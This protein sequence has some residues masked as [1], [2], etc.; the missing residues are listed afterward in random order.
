MKK[1][2]VILTLAVCPALAE[3][4]AVGTGSYATE[5]PADC[6]ALP[7]RIY[8]TDSYKG[9]PLTNQWWSSLLFEE[10]S[11]NLFAH[12]LGMVATPRGL[13]VTYVGSSI[14]SSKDAIMGAGVSK[15]GDFVISH[16]A[17]GK[18]PSAEADGHSDWFV[19]AAF[20]DGE[21]SLKTSFGH[22]SPFV[23]CLYGGGGP[24]LVFPEKPRLWSGSENDPVLGITVQGRHYGL[25]GAGGSTWEG[26]GG[27][28][29]TNRTTKP[30]FSIAVL[31]DAEPETLAL[32]RRHAYNHVTDT[33]LTHE[34]GSGSVKA[35]YSF[36]VKRWEGGEKGTITALYPHQW[37]YSRADLTGISYPSVRG[38]M[39]V[40]ICEG[41]STETPIHG[42]LPMLPPQ[43]I[44]N[45]ERILAYLREEAA[46]KPAPFADT[47]WDGKY[48]GR[49][50]TL[51]GIAEAAG[52]VGIRKTFTNEIKRRL[53]DW[54]T[55]SPG[56]A[57]PLFYYDANWRTL[58]GSK[59]SY[60]SDESINDHHF[61][62]GYFIRAAAEIARTDKAW[63]GKWRPMVELL[64][65]DIASPDRADAM[66]PHIRCF[67]R[68]AGHSW[69][70]GN[71]KFADGNNQESSSESMNAWY[72]MML[73][74]EA[75]GDAQIRDAG[76]FL[77]NTERTAVEEYWFDVS[78]T[79]F[80]VDFPQ[81]ALGMV[82]G[83]K[84][85]FA[86]WFSGDIDCI[87]GINWLPFT[88][89]STYMGRHP[90]YVK[91]NYDRIVAVREKGADLNNGWGDLVVMFGA[92]SDPGRAAAHLDANPQC[93]LEGGNTHAFMDHWIGTL[94]TLGL[95]SAG[96]VADHPF[97]AAF[98]KG[99]KTT[100]AAYHF[101]AKPLKVTFSDGTVLDAAPGGL[102]VSGK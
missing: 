18:F 49:L 45:R 59:P 19:T 101:G 15:S 2:A 35:I 32:F 23:F 84:G 52:E 28:V 68:Y 96:I 13:A 7:A 67:D 93:S 27:E 58:I 1:H 50:A 90:D 14:S 81:V 20:R 9:A 102:T 98:T 88:P 83:G 70:S 71:A 22:G 74:G 56:E 91:R 24:R 66:F 85:A 44:R 69:A 95:P 8:R 17:S 89:A 77:F 53:E 63:A 30:H 54:F 10:F 40:A 46:K 16:S 26:L 42:V 100:F 21:A 25:F 57:S 29:F 36:S 6:K 97:A 43:G 37:K 33:R 94:H 51:S 86:T 80:P 87:H 60:G 31:P 41:F 39:K 75:M 11:S 4:V 72:G 55:A 73:W 5:R 65:R 82:W 12:P 38:E 64:I 34:V 79:N 48:L 61:H 76:I 62:Y 78:G 92:L 47:Y 99:G 3:T